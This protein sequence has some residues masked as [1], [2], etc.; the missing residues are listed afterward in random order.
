MGYSKI[1]IEKFDGKGDFS[2]WKKKMRAVL[3]QQKCAKAIGDPSEF[4]EMMKSFDNQGVLETA[5]S[6]LILN[7]VN[8]VLQQV[9]EEDTALKVWNKLESLYMIK[10]LSNRF[11]LKSNSLVSKWTHLRILKRIWMIL[12]RLLLALKI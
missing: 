1:E 12:K 6:L 11:T 2:M 4:P 9:D 5:Y 3:V 10:S 7:L 8:N